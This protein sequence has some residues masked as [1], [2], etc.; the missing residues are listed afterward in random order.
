MMNSS[1]QGNENSST[2]SSTQ[3][4][5]NSSTDSSTQ[6]N[7]NSSTDSSTQGNEY[8]STDISKQS[9][10]I[11][12]V[13]SRQELEYVI[14]KAVYSTEVT[15]IHTHLYSECFNKL[16]LYGVDELLT[17]HYLV[18]ET[19]RHLDIDYSAFFELSKAEQAACVW[20]TLFVRN[21][22]VSEPAR[23]IITIFNRLG[24]D[25]N[26]KDINYFRNYFN[27]INL[28]DHIDDI[29]RLNNLKCVVMTNDP[30]DVLERSVWEC[31]FVKDDRFMAAL[32]VDILLNYW[33]RAVSE[34]NSQGYKVNYDLSDN[35]VNEVKRFLLEWIDR[36]EALYC[37]VS[38]PPDFSIKDVS[39]RAKL[40]EQC[41]LPVCR[42]RNIPFALMI[43]VKRNVNAELR[44][45]GDSLGRADI[46][47]VEALCSTFP[48]NKF[49]V[50]MLSFENQHELI[51]TARKF[52]NLMVFG[53]WWFIN[54]PTTIELITNMRVEWLGNS[55]IPQHS[56][57]RVFEQLISK[58][59][60][61]KCS[62]AKV[63]TNKYGDLL[64]MGY[65]FSKE[66]IV[67]DVEQ[68]FGENFWSFLN[69]KL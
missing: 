51:I 46:E 3:G 16:F 2:D 32:R 11:N 24:L 12:T 67:K 8:N 6:G 33:D 28:S 30:F 35:T 55:F 62:I 25:V 64:E 41:I 7:E 37:A 9:A 43:G 14:N 66:Q 36:M 52:K 21:T 60:H 4:N 49:L 50:T 26:N 1:R 17:Y 42:Q 65:T 10:V 5:E 56:D 48:Q 53:C 58:W 47:A 63:L 61:S 23:S 29:F 27:N 22:P 57:C 34:L 38:L 45:A 54:S 18:A 68:L 39:V 31:G 44:L 69:K 15:D 19:M 40:I 20:D 59:E 13:S